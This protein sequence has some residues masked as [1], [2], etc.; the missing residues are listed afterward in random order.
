MEDKY[1]IY[2][3]G[4]RGSYPVFGKQ[5]QE[6]GGSTTCYIITNGDHAIVLDCGTGL[7]NAKKLLSTCKKIDVLFSHV[8]YDHTLGLLNAGVFPKDAEVTYYGDFKTWFNKDSM[9]DTFLVHPFWPVDIAD[10]KFIQFNSDGK[11]L[12]VNKEVKFTSIPAPHPDNCSTFKIVINDK[13]ITF[14]CD[15][16]S[17]D[18]NL[19]NYSK[20]SDI[21]FYDSMFD[22]DDYE[23]HK[24]WGHSTWLQGCELAVAA[25]VKRLF[26]THHNYEYDDN[27]LFDMEKRCKQKFANSFFSRE[28]LVI[29]L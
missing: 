21:L 14:L 24:G 27:R 5:F 13:V 1:K 12:D 10:G 23:I 19:I 25:N 15:C 18:D 20:N 17:F 7:Y 2:V 11:F 28:G 22:V 29:E 4:C 9:K 3:M 6:F 26:L 8:H 16:E